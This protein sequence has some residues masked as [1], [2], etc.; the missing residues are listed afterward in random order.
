LSNHLIRTLNPVGVLNFYSHCGGSL[1]HVIHG[2]INL[3]S[4]S[5]TVNEGPTSLS[6]EN[7]LRVRN[8]AGLIVLPALFLVVV[9]KLR[10][11]KDFSLYFSHFCCH[12]YLPTLKVVTSSQ[13]IF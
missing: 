4:S 5:S 13:F 8:F 9:D 3:V 11:F 6:Q 1:S 12:F 10:R 7:W 2:L